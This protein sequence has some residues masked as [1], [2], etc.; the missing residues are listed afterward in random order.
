MSEMGNR[1][2]SIA[3]SWMD[4]NPGKVITTRTLCELS[5]VTPPTIYH[6]FENKNELLALIAE[7]KMIDFFRRKQSD[8]HSDDPTNDLLNGWNQWIQFATYNSG[9]ISALQQVPGTSRRLRIQA[10]K[11][12]LVHLGR[13]DQFHSLSMS[14]RDAAQ[15]VVAA[16]NVVA[17]MV[18]QGVP[19]S[20]IESLN[21]N[22]QNAVLKTLLQE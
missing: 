5:G 1:L 15:L 12:V 14:P 7:K 8:P 3:I 2:L 21:R 18:L 16:S 10:E 6:H 4:E 20:E 17:Q 9:L 11:I 13:I 19:S 22:L